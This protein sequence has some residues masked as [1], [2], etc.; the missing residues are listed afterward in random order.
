MPPLPRPRP[1][2]PAAPLKRADCPVPVVSS[3]RHV[4]PAKT[5]PDPSLGLKASRA[6]FAVLG[7]KWAAPV[8][9]AVARECD[10]PVLSPRQV[11]EASRGARPRAL[12]LALPGLSHKMLTGTLRH[13]E[14]G[15][16]IRR[17]AFAQAPPRVEYSLTPAGRL[18]LGLAHD[19]DAW[20]LDHPDTLPQD[21]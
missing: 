17:E 3:A 8:L 1:N 18:V 21:D 19:I 9:D 2:A 12:L 11:E 15:G 16:L 4:P 5:Q 20:C 10:R 13:L 14:Q 6:L 7:A